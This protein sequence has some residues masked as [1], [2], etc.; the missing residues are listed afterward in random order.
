LGNRL[1]LSPTDQEKYINVAKN[2]VFQ[3]ELLEAL[4]DG[5]VS[6]DEAEMLQELRKTLGLPAMDRKDFDPELRRREAAHQ[7]K[8]KQREL[9]EA[10]RDCRNQRREEAFWLAVIFAVVGGLL[11]LFALIQ[12]GTRGLIFLSFLIF[13]FLLLV[14]ALMSAILYLGAFTSTRCKYCGAHWAVQSTGEYKAQTSM[15]G[16]D[17]IDAEYEC[18]R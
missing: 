5:L 8:K 9:S 14:W 12:G 16:P 13:P 3:D 18:V 6:D 4:G 2:S 10:Q 15:W 7:K 1:Q 11:A 17:R